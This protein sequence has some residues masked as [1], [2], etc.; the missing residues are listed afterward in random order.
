MSTYQVTQNLYIIAFTICF[1]FII[2]DFLLSMMFKYLKKR[3]I[4]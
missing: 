4:I 3:G 2:A 1:G